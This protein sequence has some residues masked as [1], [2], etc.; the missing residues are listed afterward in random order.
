MGRK[1]EESA[2]AASVCIASQLTESWIA[3]PSKANSTSDLLQGRS[4]PGKNSRSIHIRRGLALL[5]RARAEGA[6]EEQHRM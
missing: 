5:R 2:R 3:D 1:T 4:R 6:S